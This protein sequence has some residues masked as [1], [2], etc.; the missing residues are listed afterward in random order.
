MITLSDIF[1]GNFQQTQGFGE[2]PD[3]YKQFGLAGHEGLDFGTPNGTPIISA[4]D[5]VVVRDF[6]DPVS[7]K[8]YGIYVAIWDKVQGCTTYYCHLQNNVVS[9]GQAVVRGQLIGYSNNTGN[10]SRPHLHFNLCKTD[11]KGN[12]TNTTNGYFGF[13]NPNDKRIVAWDIKDPK[14]PV[15]PPAITKPSFP[16]INNA[17]WLQNMFGELGIDITK[18]EGEVRGRVQEMIDGYKKYQEL[19][20]RITKMSKDLAFSA[21]QAAQFETELSL[22]KGEINTLTKSLQEAREAITARD[23]E[24]SRLTQAV[25]KL[26]QAIDP[27]TRVVIPKEEYVRL[28]AKKNLDRFTKMELLQE[29]IRRFWKR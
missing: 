8:A 10:S 21:G 9:V 13:I 4:T 16:P 19:E 29:V 5:G 22:A 24:V 26:N 28:I 25:E 23:S 12:K 2:R 7:G 17:G 6:D 3:Y 11:E 15:E 1:I 14:K 20:S 18:T 27:E